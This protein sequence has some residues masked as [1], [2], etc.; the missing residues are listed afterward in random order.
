MVLFRVAV[1]GS[2]VPGSTLPGSTLPVYNGVHCMEVYTICRSTYYGVQC[3][4]YN[5]RHELYGIH[6]TVNNVVRL[7]QGVMEDIYYYGVQ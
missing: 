7:V 1:P 6:C 4:V 2:G 5:V 3:T